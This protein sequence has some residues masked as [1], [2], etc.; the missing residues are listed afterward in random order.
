MPGAADIRR[1][2]ESVPTTIATPILSRSRSRLS[3][4]RKAIGL[5]VPQ[6]ACEDARPADLFLFLW[7]EGAR[8]EVSYLPSPQ[9]YGPSSLGG[10][11]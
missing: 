7:V 6:G 4:L 10:I 8:F 3:P 9:T 5:P 11:H 2:E 1:V